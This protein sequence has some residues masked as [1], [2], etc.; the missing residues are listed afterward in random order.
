MLDKASGG[1]LKR[2]D[3]SS[4]PSEILES[5]LRRLVELRWQ[6]EVIS[7]WLAGSATP[8]ESRSPLEEMFA[9]VNAELRTLEGIP[10]TAE[11]GAHSKQAG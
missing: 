2:A 1:R 4:E 11:G 8:V 10:A 9:Q 5:R 7:R 3:M 6:R